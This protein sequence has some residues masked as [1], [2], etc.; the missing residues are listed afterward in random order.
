MKQ[1]SMTTDEIVWRLEMLFGIDYKKVMGRDIFV[2][3]DSKIKIQYDPKTDTW[4]VNHHVGS[5]Q[6]ISY[7]VSGDGKQILLTCT[8][9]PLFFSPNEDG[10]LTDQ[11]LYLPIQ[12]VLNCPEEFDLAIFVSMWLRTLPEFQ[13]QKGRTLCESSSVIEG[14]QDKSITENSKRKN[15]SKNT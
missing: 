9:M 5:N 13:K 1:E 11:G 6:G 8:R 3:K 15:D 2:S 14:P 10:R 12:T 4:Q 7:S